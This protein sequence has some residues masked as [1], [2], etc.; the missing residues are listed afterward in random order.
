MLA[1]LEESA[2]RKEFLQ[3]DAFFEI[4]RSSAEVVAHSANEKKRLYVAGILAGTIRQGNTNDLTLQILQDLKDL[5]DFHLAILAFLP[6]QAGTAIPPT[7]PEGMTMEVYS[8]GV[9]DLERMGFIFFDNKLI[10]LVN[11]G[12]G[13]RE[14]TE[15]L[16]TFK[17]ALAV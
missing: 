14:T 7:G 5:H 11:G 13:H 8:K 17:K 16:V 1:S 6:D 12:G 2:L 4:F 3:S 9:A 15:Y 10:G